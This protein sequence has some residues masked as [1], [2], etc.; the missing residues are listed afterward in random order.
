[1]TPRLLTREEARAYLAGAD[2]VQFVDPVRIGRRVLWDK[3]AID[4]K[5][6]ALAKIQRR[7]RAE[8]ALEQWEAEVQQPIRASK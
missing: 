5:L 3:V 2:P 6:N 7:A 1:M 4:E 8:S